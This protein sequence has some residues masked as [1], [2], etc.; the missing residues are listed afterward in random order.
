M[1]AVLTRM[2]AQCAAHE[3]VSQDNEALRHGMCVQ[4]C[5]DT[6]CIVHRGWT[7]G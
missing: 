1:G 5:K 2:D 6:A 3:A 4:L 7:F